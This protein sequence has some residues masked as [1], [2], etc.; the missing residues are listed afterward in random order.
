[1]KKLMIS[2][3]MSLIILSVYSD[4][5][6]ITYSYDKT[7][8][9][10]QINYQNGST[11]SYSYDESGNRLSMFREAAP[12]DISETEI[13][14]GY[15]D[16]SV[17]IHDLKGFNFQKNAEIWISRE[18]QTNIQATDVD[19]LTPGSISCTFILSGAETG[20]WDLN[21]KN[22]DAKSDTFLNGFEVRNTLVKDWM[23]F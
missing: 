2:F 10:T 8:R 5:V 18:G 20:F 6:S 11:V 7:Y 4:P 3:F 15:S 23:L 13:Y 22:P 14:Y 16:D 19:V 21:V 12:P 1:M 17:T 9:L